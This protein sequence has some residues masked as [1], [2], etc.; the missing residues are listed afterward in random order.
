MYKLTGEHDAGKSTLI[1]HLANSTGEQGTS[2]SATARP[3][4]APTSSDIPSTPGLGLTYSHID[5]SDEGDE[6][7]FALLSSLLST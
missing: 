6:G 7:A 3:K 5:V 1:S 2:K 4:P